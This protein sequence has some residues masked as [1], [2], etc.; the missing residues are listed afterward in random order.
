M[1]EITLKGNAIH[2][3]GNLPEVGS[4]SPA[5]TLVGTDLAEA[6]LET[7]AGKKKVLNIFPSIDTGVCAQSVRTFNEKAAGLDGTV[8]LNISADLPF[9]QKRFCGAEGIENTLSLSTFRSGFAKDFGLEITDGPLAGLCSRAVI[10]LDADNKVVYTE[11]VP[12]I[13][14]EPDYEKALAALA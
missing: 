6:S 8:V 5:F 13:G 11:Q 12:E 14:Q 3:S 9:A 2:T 4:A 10:V 1:A 7:Y